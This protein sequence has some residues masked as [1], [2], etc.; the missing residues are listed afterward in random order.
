MDLLTRIAQFRNMAQA[1]PTNDMAHFSLGQALLQAGNAKEAAEAFATCVR[2][3]PEMSKAYQLAGQALAAIG[4]KGEAVRILT[5]GYRV[6]AKKGD[7]M[8]RN[9]MGEQ[10][11]AMGASIPSVQE[12]VGAGPAGVSGSF[13]CQVSGRPGTKLTK[14]PLRGRLGEKIMETVSA[15]TWKAWIAQ[16]TKVI[17]ELRL[18]LSRPE[19]DKIYEQH[20]IEFLQLTEWAEEQLPK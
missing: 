19:H 15:E 8:P 14:P 12:A 10:L 16:G 5:E 13:I 9:A 17:N 20:M 2:I 1:D 7:L 3:N 6:A 11:R 4:E 18:D